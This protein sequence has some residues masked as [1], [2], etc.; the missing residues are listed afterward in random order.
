MKLLKF[1]FG[2]IIFLLFLAVG[3]ILFL[4]FRY[5]IGTFSLIS[6]IKNVNVEIDET[7]YITNPYNEDDLNSFNISHNI[8][9]GKLS[10]K[11]QD[12][13]I[14][15]YVDSK[16]KN[17]IIIEGFDVKLKEITFTKVDDYDA[18]ISIMVRID[19]KE[20]KEKEL[21]SFPKSIAKKAIP[22]YFYVTIKSNVKIKDDRTLDIADPYIIINGQTKYDQ[23]FNVVKQFM[24]IDLNEEIKN[25]NKQALDSF[26]GKDG[27][28]DEA[29]QKHLIKGYNFNF[30]GGS[31]LEV[32]CFSLIG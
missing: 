23:I 15:A 18:N 25:A 16:L 7:T 19:M 11:F 20:F 13:E 32:V 27:Y 17:E 5:D 1:L 26:F 3:V 8:L 4:R 14:A 2:L 12:K 29:Y 22:D 24:H 28:L 31:Y 6:Q 21:N 10:V 9:A 30:D